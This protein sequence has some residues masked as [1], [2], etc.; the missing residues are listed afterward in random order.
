MYFPNCLFLTYFFIIKSCKPWMADLHLHKPSHH[1]LPCQTQTHPSH[2]F[3]QIF[4]TWPTTSQ[5]LGAFVSSPQEPGS[6]V[7]DNCWFGRFP[8][9]ETLQLPCWYLIWLLWSHAHIHTNICRQVC[10]WTRTQCLRKP[11]PVMPGVV[12]TQMVETC[13]A[14]IGQTMIHKWKWITWKRIY[15]FI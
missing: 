4:I 13:Q 5:L 10:A 3:Y 15:V 7:L 12:I 6:V 11:R 14:L 1:H 8:V 2:T 9:A